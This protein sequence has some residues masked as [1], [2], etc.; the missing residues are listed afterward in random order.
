MATALFRY[1]RSHQRRDI[2]P[3]KVAVLSH[4]CA[5]EPCAASHR[6]SAL[7][8]ALLECGHDVTVITGFK[9]FPAGKLDAADRHVLHRV[10]HRDGLRIVRLLT[11][12]PARARGGRLVSWVASAVASSIYLL[13]TRER[14]DVIVVTVPPI[15]LALP[16]LVGRLRH[17]CMLV[18]DVRDVFPDVAVAMG[19]WR[20]GSLVERAVGG[21]ARALYRASRFVV[22]V[23][24]TALEQIIVRGVD[25][26][27]LV[28]A[29]NGFD[30]ASIS[31]CGRSRRGRFRAVF[32]GNL[33][34][35]TGIDVV[36]DAA[37]LLRNEPI[38]F[39]IVGDGADAA[40]V[41]GRIEAERLENVSMTGSLPR[42]DAMRELAGAS[43]AIVPLRAG[44]IDTIPSKIFDALA[45]A[46]P[47]VVCAEGEAASLASSS[48]GA[49]VVR[50]GDGRE[51]ATALQQLAADPDRREAMGRRGRAYVR[52]RFERRRIM[53]EL[54]ARF[55]R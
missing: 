30:D 41:R 5:P 24:Q 6:V 42:A 37:G 7:C 34:I 53:R 12:D 33:G 52:E 47:V 15:T 14:F 48:G 32:A 19:E 10:E 23:T 49:V 29:P 46:L 27:H 39:T 22:A 44:L 1:D 18:T 2:T 16:A 38:E 31:D 4:F 43:V 17:R 25:R 50:P 26:S 11:L 20:E 55:A 28:L 8:A 3:V 51:L 54:C 9:T 13:L 45:L 36:L 35:A 40:R 21:L